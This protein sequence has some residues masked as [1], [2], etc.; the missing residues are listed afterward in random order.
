[1]GLPLPGIEM[2]IR[3]LDDPR[4]ELGPNETPDELAPDPIIG[5]MRDAADELDEIVADAM[6]PAAGRSGPGFRR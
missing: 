5:S 6:K 2:G 4:L 3:A 1:M